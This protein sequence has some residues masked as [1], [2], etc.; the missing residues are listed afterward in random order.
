MRV[1]GFGYTL[2]TAA[3]F[4]LGT[5]L[6]KL[7]VAELPALLLTFLAFL[8]GGS[9][10]ALL[11]VLRR[12]PLIPRLTAPQWRQMV[13]LVVLG[14]AL[15]LTL[16]AEGFARTSAIKGSFLIQANGIAALVFAV[17]LL[18][19]RLTWRHGLGIFMMLLGSML[20]IAPRTAVGTW[21]GL[22][23]GDL[24]VLLG[25][26]GLGYAYIPSKQL[27]AELP[28]LQV[29]ALRLLLGAAMLLPLVL[30][31]V[32]IPSIPAS[33]AVLWALPLLAATNYAL[34]YVTLQAGLRLLRAWEVAAVMQTLPLF[35]AIFAVLWMHD[36]LTLPQL[37]GALLSLAG[38]VVLSLGDFEPRQVAAPADM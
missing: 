11:L 7:L 26:I 4:G 18:G 16:I 1:R 36:T 33:P 15:P 17:A 19:E 8:G 32:G 6:T 10:L 21:G 34:A 29:S 12:T 20:L 2:A 30:A 25:A 38:G 3:M 5:V 22:N 31:L 28:A 37:I 14:T 13:L 23:A 24:L 27:A 35:A 9:L